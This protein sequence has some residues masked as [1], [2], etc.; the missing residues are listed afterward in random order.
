M[1]S[2]FSSSHHPDIKFDASDAPGFMFK[3]MQFADISLLDDLFPS[4][5][6]KTP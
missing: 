5:G 1:E 3:V 6:S 4:A 2:A